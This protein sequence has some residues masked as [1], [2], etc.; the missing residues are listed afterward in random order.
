MGIFEFLFRIFD[1]IAWIGTAN[2]PVEIVFAVYNI[3]ILLVNYL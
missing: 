2:G 3:L 1:N